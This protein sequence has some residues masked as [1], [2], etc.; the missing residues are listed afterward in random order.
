MSAFCLCQRK[1]ERGSGM[2]AKEYKYIKHSDKQHA[3]ILETAKKLFME[4]EIKDV[5]MTQIAK[6]CGITRAT[7]YRYF[8]NKDAVVWEIYISFGKKWMDTLWGEIHGKKVSTYEKMAV[9]LRG[10][11]DV[12]IEMPEFYKFFFH[13]SKEYLNN[14]MYSDTV[15]GKELFKNTGL[16]AGST[17][18]FMIEDFED[19]SMREGLDA[20]TTGISVAYGA[21][22]FIRVVCDNMD[23]IP[24]KY[25]VSP[26]QVLVDGM[27][28][29]LVAIKRDDYQ[30]EFAE[31][32]W[33]DLKV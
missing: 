14:Q 24:L 30:S 26:I 32:I 16:A 29:M 18:A 2:M 8:E 13:F 9:Y 25:G 33:D 6:E 1:M 7:L 20:K 23:S 27:K 22:G 3:M 10:M 12:F 21:I 11:L 5:S 31:N 4:N 17:V 28:N 19:G 15:Y